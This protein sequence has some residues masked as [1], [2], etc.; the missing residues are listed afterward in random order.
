V[1]HAGTHAWGEA[2]D[3]NPRYAPAPHPSV[4]LSRCTTRCGRHHQPLSW[5][6]AVGD[7]ASY[8]VGAQREAHTA[9]RP[10]I[11][12]E[13]IWWLLPSAASERRRVISSAS[14]RSQWR[15]RHRHPAALEPK[16]PAD[17]KPMP[18]GETREDSTIAIDSLFLASASV[19]AL[20]GW[21]YPACNSVQKP[22]GGR[23]QVHRSV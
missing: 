8:R 10:P 23:T 16:R 15:V 14:P 17:R 13:Q 5:P 20:F 11:Q 3:P 4:Q 6:L 18:H 22:I 1:F 9:R 12:R 7:W 21:N 19:G 2:M